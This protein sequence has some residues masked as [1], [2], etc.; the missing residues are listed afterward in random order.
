LIKKE[1]ALMKTMLRIEFQ[2]FIF[3]QSTN[4]NACWD[5]SYCFL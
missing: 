2:G 5:L 4:F 3:E 1:V